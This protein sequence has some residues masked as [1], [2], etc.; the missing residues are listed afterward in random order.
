MSRRGNMNF[1]TVLK[2]SNCLNAKPE[3]MKIDSEKRFEIAKEQ[4]ELCKQNGHLNFTTE[5]LIKSYIESVCNSENANKNYILPLYFVQELNE[6]DS[7]L[8]EKILK[9]YTE[10]VLPYIQDFSFVSESINRY[11][12]K[13]DQIDKIIEC[14]KEYTIADRVLLNHE[15]ISKRFNIVQEIEKA[16]NKGLREVVNRCC[17][18][19][20]TYTIPP[21]AKMNLCFEE[22]SYLLDKGGIS[23]KKKDLVKYVTEYFLLRDATMSDNDL[24]GFQYVLKENYFLEEEDLKSVN[25]VLN[26]PESNIDTEELVSVK[27]EIQCFLISKNKTLQGLN[28]LFHVFLN[29]ARISDIKH[30]ID[31]ICWFLWE[32][33]QSD[34]FDQ[35][36]MEENIPLFLDLIV[37]K[38]TNC[39]NYLGNEIDY[40]DRIDH[41]N[42]NDLIEN[43]QRVQS[44][45][46]ISNYEEQYEETVRKIRFKNYLQQFI[47]KM[48]NIR[49]LIFTNKINQEAID[50][51]NS[52]DIKPIPLKEYKI[53]K[54]HNLV[55][56]CMNL[57]K[58][59]KYKAKKIYKNGAKKTKY[60]V[61]KIK[62]IL[63]GESMDLF[64]YIGE[65]AK[66]D[67][68]RMQILYD[69]S[70]E[71]EVKDL[72]EEICKEFNSQLV[73]ENMDTIRCYYIMNPDVA[74]I[75][76]KEATPVILTDSEWDLVR[77]TYND[78]FD[79][80]IESF[81]K[82]AVC[83]E[84][85]ESLSE[86][87]LMNIEEVLNDILASDQLSLEAYEVTMEALS[88]LDV[89]K[90]QVNLFTESF[91]NARYSRYV[92]ESGELTDREYK[93]ENRLTKQIAQDWNATSQVPLDIQLEAFECLLAISEAIK[94]PQVK[95]P[96]VG[97]DAVKANKDYKKPKDDP[98][99]K[100]DES[101]KNPFK[102]IN[103]NSI[104][105]YLEGLKT[106]MKQA[107]GK[108]KEIS[109]NLDNG[110][111]RFV[112]SLKDALISDRREAI[113]KGS[114]IPSFSKCIKIAISLAGTG[115]VTGNPVVPLLIAMG[116][117]AVSKRL[118]KKE[119]IL[120]LDEIETELEVVEKEINLAESKNQMKKY[121]VLLKY[122]KDL[123]RQ[124][125]RIRY[126]VRVGK[127][128]LPGSAA[129]FQNRD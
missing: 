89:S 38:F 119:R 8:S 96:K 111:R 87:Y 58:Y 121:R 107:S 75:H 48:E 83:L 103:L 44:L 115:L 6:L 125:Q 27:K 80:Y 82:T 95:K 4:L 110:F 52:D 36:A 10:R 91:N 60:T 55:R 37:L 129:G 93:K 126:N 41:Q 33:Y 46:S 15:K 81:A 1:G 2:R 42:I 56:A 28:D 65:D 78:S 9:D 102:G 14:A 122:K 117:F 77:E 53:F 118:T 45:L 25:Y 31:S 43:V 39:L 128:I 5:N 68:C 114:V 90:D 113:I 23:Y 40:F 22:F 108:E 127:D 57:D 109:R 61:K 21:Y 12:L 106:K 69:E 84:A 123:Q 47:D 116:G 3:S 86:E 54:F 79:I 72:L 49:R 18:M 34:I 62:D 67:I 19:I 63:F 98:N 13:E 120:L 7:D 64:S 11:D 50:Y 29:K 76:L 51:V 17:S 100:V 70:C 101:R 74:E 112:K 30:S 104:R 92:I 24:K 32:I 73:C 59:L 35:K 97:P 20:D 124:Y 16:P 88:F 94:K 26:P 66:A 85:Y 71:T 99:T 105:L